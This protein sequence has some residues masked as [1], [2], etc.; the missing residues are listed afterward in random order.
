MPDFSVDK[1]SNNRVATW[2]ST[3]GHAMELAAIPGTEH[4]TSRVREGVISGE[5]VELVDLISSSI[6]DNDSFVD[7]NGVVNFKYQRSKKAISN[8]FKWLEAWGNVRA[9]PM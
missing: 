6:S 2:P 5:F 9:P 3:H 7:N 1:P 8:S 4:V